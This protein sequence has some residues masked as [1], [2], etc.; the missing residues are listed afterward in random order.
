[1]RTVFIAFASIIAI[2]VVYNAARIALS[3]RAREL[4]TLRVLGFT[5][6]EVSAILLGELGGAAG[7]GDP[8]GLRCSA[9]CFTL[10]DHPDIDTELYRF[11]I[12]HL[13]GDVPDR[14]RRGSVRGGVRRL[15]RAPQDRPPRSGRGAQVEGMTESE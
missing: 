7:A 13:G 15:H 5:R 3:D 10:V 8:A 6:G 12:D 9:G 1:M 14:D 2:G 11:P 4:A